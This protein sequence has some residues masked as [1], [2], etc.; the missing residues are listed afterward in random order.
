MKA[1]IL[2]AG[3][4]KRLKPLTD[5]QP[6]C[7][8][9]FRGKPIIGYILE[10]MRQCGVHDVTVVTGYKSEVLQKY[11]EKFSVKTMANHRYET[12]NMVETLFCAEPEMTDDIIISYA[13][14]IYNEDILRKLILSKDNVSVIVDKNWKALWDRRMDNPLN[15]AE[16]MKINPEGYI[17]ELGKRAI[18]YDDIQGQYIGLL[19]I[20]KN[21]IGK[22]KDFYRDLDRK[23]VYDGKDFHNMFMTTFIQLIIDRLMPVKA[24][25]IHG[26]WLEIDTLTDLR[27]YEEVT[28]EK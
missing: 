21:V 7:L 4:G 26:G 27:R 10:A 6:K 8:V 22:I 24:I 3:E 16:T 23:A 15:D 5:N 11:L 13:D 1:I 25:D 28:S 20:F 9:E 18:S 19:K 14:I 17:T 2:A 12:T